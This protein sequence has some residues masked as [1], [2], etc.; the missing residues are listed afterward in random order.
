MDGREDL[1]LAFLRGFL[2]EPTDLEGPLSR[3]DLEGARRAAHDLKGIALTLA[4]GPLAEDASRLEDLLEAGEP[5]EEAW[6]PVKA[7]LED[8]L[9]RAR[10]V[11]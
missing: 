3:G 11:T 10:R 9:Q 6:P 7:R 1:L 5:W 4:Q 8:F 2:E